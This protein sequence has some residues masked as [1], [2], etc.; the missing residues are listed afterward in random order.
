MPQS[1]PWRRE[2][3]D[4]SVCV[5]V[6]QGVIDALDKRAA[7]LNVPR[8]EIVRAAFYGLT[9]TDGWPSEHPAMATLD[10]IHRELEKA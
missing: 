9:G 1:S 6:P 10:A 2:T 5:R 7:R 4:G 3:L 8:S